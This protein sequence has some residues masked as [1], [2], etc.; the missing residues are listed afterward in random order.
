MPTHHGTHSLLWCGKLDESHA[1]GAPICMHDEA[2]TTRLDLVAIEKLSHICATGFE[3][4]AL[5]FENPLTTKTQRQCG[6]H[7]FARH[8]HTGCVGNKWME[9]LTVRMEHVT[10][11]ASQ[12]KA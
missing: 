11:G 2:D 1:S 5:N 8:L 4:D 10:R 6:L 12:K 7:L 3:R 9:V